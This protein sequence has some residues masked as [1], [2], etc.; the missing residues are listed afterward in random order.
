VDNKS[1]IYSLGLMLNELFTAELALGINYTTVGSVAGDYSFLDSV[2][3][4]MLQQA[5]TSRYVDID[6]LK[7]D[8]LAR[9]DEQVSMQKL[10]RLRDTVI[11]T[12]EVD[13]LLVADP[14][15]IIN[16][17]WEDGVLT[18]EL[19]HQVNPNWNWALKNM[20]GYSSVMGKGP[21]V[22]QFAGKFARIAANGNEVQSV[23]DHFKDWLPMANQ[24]Y[25][26][27]LKRDI[28]TTERQQMEEIKMQIKKEEE[29]TK[30][31]S[32]LRF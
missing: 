30:I 25:E 7:R 12:N 15:R 5:P 18:I 13:D 9:S 20:G 26:N 23:I 27:K 8:L 1:D 17:D 28:E 14:M 10:S 21:E 31:K 16:C 19:N 2:V 29:R 11:P 6:E 3:E 32:N 22:F 4:I 24:A